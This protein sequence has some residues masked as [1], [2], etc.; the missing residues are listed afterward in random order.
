M[1][2]IQQK[3]IEFT[4]EE[5]LEKA[6]DIVFNDYLHCKLYYLENENNIYEI[7]WK[8]S[9]VE[10]EKKLAEMQNGMSYEMEQEY[11]Q[12]EGIVT[13]LEYFKAETEKWK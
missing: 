2:T 4:Q 6:L 12:W 7:K 10:F 3:I 1:K 8:M 9:F 11:Y 13:E 5:N